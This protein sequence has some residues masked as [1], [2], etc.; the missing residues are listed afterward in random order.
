MHTAQDVKK[1]LSDMSARC[2]LALEVIGERNERIDELEADVADM[3]S[4]FHSQL[5]VRVLFEACACIQ[6]QCCSTAMTRMLC[7]VLCCAVHAYVAHSLACAP[8]SAMQTLKSVRP[9]E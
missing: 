6:N 9:D 4:I 1:R 7:A 5:E 3:R 8:P 2:D